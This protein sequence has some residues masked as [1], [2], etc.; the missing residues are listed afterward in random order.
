MEPDNDKAARPAGAYYLLMAMFSGFS[1]MYVD[2]KFN[3]AGDSAATI[4]RILDSAWLYRLGFLS[5]LAGQVLF[6][7]LAH[8]LY[9]L[10]K[11]IDKGQARLMVILVV[12]SVPITCLNMLFQM[13]PLALLG[14]PGRFPAFAAAQLRD[15]AM[16][17]LELQ[18]LGVFIAEI[19]WGLW[20]LP[21][22][23]LVFK[24]GFF[25]KWLGVLLMLGCSGYLVECL[26]MFLFPGHQA[27]AYPG[28]ALS[29][30]AEFSFMYWA[31]FKR[32][33]VRTAA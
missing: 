1:M 3:V 6:L 15:L 17:F 10:L 27:L 28:L 32:L 13:A 8:A 2:G 30:A 26:M 22:G 24:S 9:Q 4:A 20:L 19:F 25:P 12:A 11:A 18:K 29:A 31:L 16:A 33:R 21:F 5:N 14:D 7:F 23:L